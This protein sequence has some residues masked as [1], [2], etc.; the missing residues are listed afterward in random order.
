MGRHAMAWVPKC[1]FR[2]HLGRRVRVLNTVVPW[3][4]PSLLRHMVP[5]SRLLF[6]SRLSP[7]TALRLRVHMLHPLEYF[8]VETR[9]KSLAEVWGEVAGRVIDWLVCLKR[10]STGLWC[11][12]ILGSNDVAAT[13]VPLPHVLLPLPSCGSLVLGHEVATGSSRGPHL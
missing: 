5:L 4:R 11:R 6:E 2:G 10:A 12:V 3:L 13:S 8:L 1:P 7:C 9:A